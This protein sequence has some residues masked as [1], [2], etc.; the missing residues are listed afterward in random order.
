MDG[1]HSMTPIRTIAF[2]YPGAMGASLARTLHIRQPRLTL[3]T[4]LSTRSQATLDR[5]SSSGLHNVPLP[6]LVDRSDVIIS[7]LPPSAAFTLVQEVIT[8]LPHRK[9][10]IPSVYI[11][12]NA[13]SPTTVTQMSALLQPHKIPFIDGGVLGLPATDMWDPKIYLSSAQQWERHMQEVVQVLG[14]GGEGKGLKIEVL[15]G[16]G[17]GAGSALKMCYGGINKGFNGL[18]A[19]IVMGEWCGPPRISQSKI[20]ANGVSSIPPY[21]SVS[22]T[23]CPYTTR[24]QLL[25]L[26][27]LGR[28]M[29]S[30]ANSPYPR[31]VNW[32]ASHVHS[33]I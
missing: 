11:D 25:T 29:L 17:E 26:I 3:L 6:E 30:F 32:T 23:S 14:G 19:L 16:A 28:P 21:M 15:E 31:P 33:R 5:A 7:I 8:A 2:L 27:H 9:S 22:A 12:A 10:L 4:S 18:A 24:V 13:I 1:K 20:Q